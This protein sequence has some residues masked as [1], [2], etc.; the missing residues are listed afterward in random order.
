MRAMFETIGGQRPEMV[1][2]LG[3]DDARLLWALRRLALMA[4]LGSAR[5]QA[6]HVALQQDFGDAGLGI[7]HLLRCLAFGLARC[8]S[9]RLAIGT[10]CC[11]VVTSD[12]AA[13]LAILA[14]PETS[15]AALIALAG[16]A[17]LRLRPLFE[18]LRLL[19]DGRRNW[20]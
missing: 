13:L 1:A 5:C 12:E 2:A 11:A 7:E 20:H 6:V 9:R 14:W 4:P 17:A 10:P 8:A 16:P 3:D 18:A 15:D 19:I